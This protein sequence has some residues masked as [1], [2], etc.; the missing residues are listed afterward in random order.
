[1]PSHLA[2]E[3]CS[4]KSSQA[5]STATTGTPRLDKLATAVGK[6]LITIDH[7]HHAKPEASNTL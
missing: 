2:G 3:G 5:N 4:F 1:M 6:R 7:N